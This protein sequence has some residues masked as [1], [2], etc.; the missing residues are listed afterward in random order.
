MTTELMD[1]ALLAVYQER[2][3]AL[4]YEDGDGDGFVETLILCPQIDEHCRVSSLRVLPETG[5]EGQYP[6]KQWWQGRRIPGRQISAVNAEVL[7]AL[8]I[9]SDIPGDNLIV[10]GFDL[11]K[12]E[13]GETLRIGDC[14]LIATATPHHPCRKLALRTSLTKKAAITVGRLR[15]T[16]FNACA[17]GTIFV[18]DRVERIYL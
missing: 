6:G 16:L 15:G 3:Q 4:Q 13:P 1:E 2:L 17:P 9:A 11:S 10:R 7:D 8:E 14:L 18:G 12:V 5:V